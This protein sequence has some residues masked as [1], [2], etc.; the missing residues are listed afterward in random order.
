VSSPYDD[1]RSSL[2]DRRDDPLRSRHWTVDQAARLDRPF[3]LNAPVGNGGANRTEDVGLVEAALSETRYMNKQATESPA[4]GHHGTHLDQAVRAF[5]RDNDLKEDGLLNPAGPT[6]TTLAKTF[7]ETAPRLPRPVLSYQPVMKKLS[8]EAHAANQRSVDYMKTSA[9]DGLFPQL[10]AE[11]F[12]EAGMLRAKAVDFLAQLRRHDPDRAKIVR[13]KA[14]PFLGRTEAALLDRLV[15]DLATE[16]AEEALALKQRIAARRPL[17]EDGEGGDGTPEPDAPSPGDPS[18]PSES[19]PDEKKCRQL[20]VDLANAEQAAKEAR[21]RAREFDAEFEKWQKEIVRL[22]AKVD[23]IL[24]KLAFE[25]GGPVIDV[26]RKLGKLKKIA[27]ALESFKP[28]DVS[29]VVE[30]MA[31]R[32][33]LKEAEVKS[34]EARD[35]RDFHETVAEDEEVKAGAIRDEMEAISC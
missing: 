17:G 23:E 19:K 4:K 6:V 22:T 24:A 33:E 8:G 21:D 18:K 35:R 1:R 30:L 15:D 11:D 27:D 12:R 20:A 3:A 25:I 16:R 10:L 7:G 9:G 32:N 13:K 28:R 31:A 29:T 2:L 14:D 34:E 5:Q 26:I